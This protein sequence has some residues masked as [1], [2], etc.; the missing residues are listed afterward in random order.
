MNEKE[1]SSFSLASLVAIYP[2]QPKDLYYDGCILGH[3]EVL[4]TEMAMSLFR[5]PTRVN[6]FGAV[7]CSK[8]SV[9]VTSNLKHCVIESQTLFVCPPRTIIQLESQEEAS[10]HF[11]LCEEEFLSRIQ[12]DLKQMMHLFMAV[13]ENPC[14][15]LS[16]T[17]R[18][19]IFRSQSDIRAEWRSGR[20]DPLSQEIMRML[21]RTLAYRLCRL[22]DNRIGEGRQ[23]PEEEENPTRKRNNAYFNAFIEELSKHYMHARNVG[24]YAERLHLTPKYL[25][26]LLRTTT[27]RTA[28]E[29]IDE[30]VVLEAKNLLKHSP[31]NIQEI[32][33]Y[34]N[35]SNQ[36]FFG[37]YFKQHT[38]V[39]PTAYRSSK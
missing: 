10:I 14:L 15:P 1:I 32:A 2:P 26:T 30:Y 28:T 22:I 21:F 38:G 12:I 9:T 23:N 29:W 37:K 4:D 8:G 13:R 3:R 17:E 7:F 35:F 27:G 18:D 5:F 6:A 16:R 39:T 24:F 34:L 25:T 20:Q 31:M 36:S 19:E 33:Y 11:I